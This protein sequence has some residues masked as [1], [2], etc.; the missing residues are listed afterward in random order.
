MRLTHRASE[1]SR[2][3]SARSSS[4]RSSIVGSNVTRGSIIASRISTT[5]RCSTVSGSSG[6]IGRRAALAES[7]ADSVRGIP[8]RREL[9]DVVSASAPVA[10]VQPGSAE[11]ADRPGRRRGRGTS[12][13][14][15]GRTRVPTASI[16]SRFPAR[17]ATSI[18]ITTMLSA[19]PSTAPMMSE[20]AGMSLDAAA[21]PI[22]ADRDRL[23]WP[24]HDAVVREL[25]DRVRGRRR[26][27]SEVEHEVRRGGARVDERERDHMPASAATSVAGPSAMRTG[28][29]WYSA[30]FMMPRPRKKTPTISAASAIRVPMFEPPRSASTGTYTA[31]TLRVMAI[32]IVIA[33]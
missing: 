32:A 23:P 22:L 9:L 30:A 8:Q 29:G 2:C 25:D 5:S 10:S 4:W 12:A 19:T 17:C 28:S 33:A 13:G 27:L 6:R 21:K 14:T 3:A 15:A 31:S 7:R 16:R 18:T 26:L 1:P 20:A 24:R 11:T